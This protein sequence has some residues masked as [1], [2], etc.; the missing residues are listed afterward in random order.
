MLTLRSTIYRACMATHSQ[1]IRKNCFYSSESRKLAA[2]IKALSA[3]AC[4]ER[5][6]TIGCKN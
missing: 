5:Q 3:T 2:Q 1:T 4:A 6:R